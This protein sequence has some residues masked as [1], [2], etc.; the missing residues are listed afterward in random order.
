MAFSNFST[1]KT[2]FKVFLSA[3]ACEPIKGSEPGIGWNVATELSKFHEVHVLTRANN[4]E[5]IEEHLK[6]Q[7]YPSLTFHYYD[8]PKK[9]TF[10]KKKKRGYRFYYYLWQYTAFIKYKRY[11]NENGFDIVHHI[12]F[13]NFA[14]PAAFVFL[15]PITIWGPVRKLNT[16]DVIFKSLPF[17]I[18]IIE[19]IRQF[20]IWFLTNF[21]PGRVLT[22]IKTNWIL[23]TPDLENRSCFPRKYNSKIIYHHQTGINTS[24][25]EY[26]LPTAV[27]KFGYVRLVICSEFFHWK[28]VTYSAEV[29]SRIAQKRDNVELVICGLGP[30]ENEM[31]KIFN[32]YNVSHRVSFLG[33]LNKREMLI[34]LQNCDILLYPSYHH[35]LATIVLQ[36]M[37]VGLPIVAMRGDSISSIIAGECGLVADGTNYE[38]LINSLENL[39]LRLID[40][41]ELRFNFSER[42][43][44]LIKTRYEWTELIK[45]LD[46]IY[47]YIFS[48][49]LSAEMETGSA[50]ESVK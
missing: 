25:P 16:P 21:E 41:E 7:S 17:K 19:R 29:F 3:Y 30:E 9:I 50:Q 12:T 33:F 26:N 8:L 48:R 31:K 23:E 13:S 39:T 14:M 24:E 40:D 35:G 20:L 43:K 32:R 4:K 27:K 22:P 47:R 2:R 1:D 46:S 38:E 42:G 28:G 5:V 45:N 44:A 37:Y 18:M 6:N 10:W 36:A 11:V 15:K 34:T 49:A